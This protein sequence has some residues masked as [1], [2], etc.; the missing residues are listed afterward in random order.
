MA[1]V[2]GLDRTIRGLLSFLSK[3]VIELVPRIGPL[4][5]PIFSIH[6][7]PIPGGH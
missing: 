3:V 6:L 4:T 7:E 1:L 5:S 2:N